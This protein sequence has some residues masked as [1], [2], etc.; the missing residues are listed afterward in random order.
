MSHILSDNE[1]NNKT[2]ACININAYIIATYDNQFLLSLKKSDFLI[3]DG[4]GVVIVND[5]FN[6]N[7]F[8]KISGNDVF[9]TLIDSGCLKEKRVFFLGS[10]KSNIEKIKSIMINSK[11]VGVVSG[12]SPPF[13]DKFDKK[14]NIIIH[15][16]IN[17]FEPDLL[18]LG[19]SAPKQE[20]WIFEN[21]SFIKFKLACSVGAVFN[22]ITNEEK[23]C[24]EIL[25]RLNLEWAW[26][27]IQN[28]K[29]L[30][31]NFKGIPIYAINIVY[32][33]VINYIKYIFKF[34]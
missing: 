10:T 32:N 24:P 13:K 12:F 3:P 15:K 33:I 14:D 6:L 19:M 4:A 29:L 7:I 2:L 34:L 17:E 11:K 31:R 8:E 21:K 23:K 30:Y 9:E 26:R 27:S 25:N 22:F 18:L 1:Y 5:Y 20:K 28:K 16:I